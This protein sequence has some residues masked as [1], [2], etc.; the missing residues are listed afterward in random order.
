MMFGFI[1]KQKLIKD[2]LKGIAKLMYQDVSKDPWDREN[3]TKMNLDYS[4]ES[5][6]WIDRYIERLMGRK[7]ETD[8]LND[9]FNHFVSRIGAYAGEVIKR[10]LRQDFH[11]YEAQSV[12]RHS[13][14]PAAGQVERDIE[15][16]I[17]SKTK[18]E[19]ISPLSIA[20]GMLKGSSPY[21]CLLVYVEQTIREQS[22]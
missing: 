10:E 18:D 1:N 13:S 8:L 21:P 3:L 11:W 17:Y 12:Y 20:S 15:T 7:Y 14:N 19:V 2:D 4:V 9:H 6:R 5:V 22:G 16:V